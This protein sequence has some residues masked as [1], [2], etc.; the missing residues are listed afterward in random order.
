MAAGVL[1]NLEAA[2]DDFFFFLRGWRRMISTEQ[3]QVIDC[4]D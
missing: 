3:F 4:Y 2:A 1:F